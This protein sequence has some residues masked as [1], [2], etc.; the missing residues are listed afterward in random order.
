MNLVPENFSQT[1]YYGLSAMNQVNL[2]VLIWWDWHLE[3][4][5]A[6][7]GAK[8]FRVMGWRQTGSKGPWQTCT[9]H[10][11]NFCQ[12]PCLGRSAIYS[13]PNIRKRN[14]YVSHWP[15][16]AHCQR[17]L[18]E[19]GLLSLS[20]N[21][22]P[23]MTTIPDLIRKDEWNGHSSQRRTQRGHEVWRMDWWVPLSGGIAGRHPELQ[24][25]AGDGALHGSQT[26]LQPEAPECCA[27]LVPPYF[28]G[29]CEAT[30]C[31]AHHPSPWLAK[32]YFSLR[33]KLRRCVPQMPLLSLCH[34]FCVPYL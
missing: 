22:D 34:P 29:C 30:C 18:R 26:V 2:H 25:P 32:T 31:Q 17:K 13:Q 3:S 23:K 1:V 10:I 20:L 19:T 21:M 27:L 6:R 14:R 11:D 4:H 33:S 28:Q 8:H 24:A 12:D 9:L 7:I 15:Q 5:G 16:G